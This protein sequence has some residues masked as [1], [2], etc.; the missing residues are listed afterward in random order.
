MRDR[1]QLAKEGPGLN[2]APTGPVPTLSMRDGT[3]SMRD[4]SGKVII[5]HHSLIRC[6]ESLITHAGDDVSREGLKDTPQR[7]IASYATIYGGYKFTEDDIAK[8]LKNFEEK[9]DEMV[10]L[11]HC[12]FYST[13]EHH[14]QP[15]F[16]KA[17]IAY[18]PDKKVVGVSKLAR[19]LEVFARR[20]QIQERIGTQIVEALE[21]YV[22]GIKGAACVLQAKHFCMVCRGVEKQN[23]IMTTSALRGEFLQPEVR[24]EFLKLIELAKGNL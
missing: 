6:V 7:V 17:H 21:K 3:A 24:A 11:S 2:I 23:S 1:D 4:G 19:L 14:M 8:L 13:C 18:L 22:P 10:L 15:F 5:P 20:L 16:G 12:E 9:S